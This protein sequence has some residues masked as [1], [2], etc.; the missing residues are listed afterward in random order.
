MKGMTIIVKTITNWVKVLIFLFGLYIVIFGHAT[1]GGGF[2]GGVILVGAYVLIMLAFG[3]DAMVANLSPRLARKLLSVGAASFGL[4][5]L[6]GFLFGS[7]KFLWNF[8]YQ[9][10]PDC[11]VFGGGIIDL[12]EFAIG[13][14][15]TMSLFLVIFT[16]SVYCKD[17]KCKDDQ[18]DIPAEE[19]EQN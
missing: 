1:P 4:I 15:V 10:W 5:A 9:K 11:K 2:A 13:L 19:K 7:D 16:L 6:S 3:K 18:C 8:I 12:A 17:F 14:A